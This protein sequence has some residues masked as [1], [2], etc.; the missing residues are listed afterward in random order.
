MDKKWLASS[1]KHI[2]GPDRV[3]EGDLDHRMYSYDSSF[4]ARLNTFIPDA[5]VF[6][7]ST[8]QVAAVMRFAYAHNIPV[9]PRGAGTGETCGCIAVRGGIVLDL[10]PWD[11]I[12]EVDDANMQV[13][14]RPGVIH[15]KLNAHL[16][17]HGL[18]F[19]PDPGSSRMCTLGGMVANNSSG[20]RAV[21]YGTTEHYVLGLEVVLPDGEVIIT[22]GAACRAIKNVSG[23]NLTRLFTGSEGVLGVITL[24]RLRLWPKPKARGIVMAQLSSLADATPTVLEVYRSGILPSGVEILDDSAI[25]AVNLYHPEA[26]LPGEA[27][28]ILLFEVDGN[29]ASVQWEGE[30]I[31]A[32]AG[33][34]AARVEWATEAGR[35]ADLWQGRSLVAAA[36][37]RLQ[38]GGT[39]I[40]AGEDIC[41]PLSRVT[42]ALE[43]IKALGQKYGLT[44]VNY[45]HIG[46]GNIH[47]APVIDPR[48]R[49]QVIRAGYLTDE[50]HRLAIRLGGST[51]G[52]HG[53]GAVRS[54]F[55]REEHGAALDTMLKVK[56]ALDPKNIMNPGKIFPGVEGE[57]A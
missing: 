3:L 22:G 19:P 1:L 7:A 31:A 52:E 28:A 57:Q 12:E 50:I 27:E 46:D 29:P 6:P 21:K 8:E 48:D 44:V 37:A 36:A 35:M 2:L 38:S 25:R 51:T 33:R 15:A 43:Q 13:L 11:K 55:A 4:L 54:C 40:F 39:R 17:P 5:V 18:F 10:S 56:R 24:I 47:T 14:V 26:D 45:G 42:E 49:D 53:V 16:E 34:R 20:L 32:I 30:Q 23:L 41:V 9:T